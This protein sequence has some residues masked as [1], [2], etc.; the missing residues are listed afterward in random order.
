MRNRR[1]NLKK[2]LK[3]QPQTTGK[4]TAKP[5]T[6]NG[7]KKDPACRKDRIEIGCNKIERFTESKIA[8]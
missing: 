7:R 4:K 6:K 1:R 8:L 2:L 5:K 3:H